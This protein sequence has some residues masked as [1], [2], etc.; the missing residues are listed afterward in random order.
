[1]RLK[2]LLAVFLFWL[3]FAASTAYACGCGIYVPRDG[4]V[5][6]TQERA[7]VRWDGTREDI[8]MSLGVLG[9]SAEAAIILPIPAR[10]EVKLAPSNLFDDLAEL[11]KPLVREETEWTFGLEGVGAMPDA[12]GG[13]PRGVNVL[14][15]QNVGPFDVA[16]LAA[17]DKDALKNWLDENDFQLDAGVID[18]MQPYVADD[19]TFVAVRLRPENA[20][21]ELGGDLQPLWI[22][23]DSDTLVYPMRASANA[24]NS[25]QLWLYI[26]ADHRVEKQNAF[27]A[28][29]VS[30]ADW[31]EPANVSNTALAPFVP[32]KFFLT[33]FSDTVNPAQ[34]NDD[35]NFSFAPQDAQFRQ[36]TIRRVK[37]DATPFLLLACLGILLFG[38]LGVVLLVVMIVQRRALQPR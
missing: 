25:Q 22:S 23:F 8:V 3:A 6:V 33:K 32:R 26:L 27:G 19:W 18:L 20:G 2:I 15:R 10:A 13:A 35:F 37:Q 5:S 7:L 17:T 21:Q 34:V 1:M 38:F 30:F 31:L 9:E 16:N 11:T 12:A 14:S 36:V 24:K 28:S 4:D 29:R